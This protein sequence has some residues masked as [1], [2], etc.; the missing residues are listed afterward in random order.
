M[1]DNDSSAPAG[2]VPGDSEQVTK[3]AAAAARALG[4]RF[5]ITAEGV[6]SLYGV[7][8]TS[9]EAAMLQALWRRVAA[10]ERAVAEL[11]GTKAL[12]LFDDAAGEDPATRPASRR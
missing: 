7:S 2:Y 12:N 6:A 11:Q 1:A 8:A 10:L 5:E 3:D 4:A 9:L